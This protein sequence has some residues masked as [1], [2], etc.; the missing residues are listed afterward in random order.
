MEIA[1]PV[2]K[3]CK[4]SPDTHILHSTFSIEQACLLLLFPLFL[5]RKPENLNSSMQALGEKISCYK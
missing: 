2:F 1:T 5:L 4:A 3:A